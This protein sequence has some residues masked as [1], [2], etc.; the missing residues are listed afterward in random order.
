MGPRLRGDDVSEG[1][2]QSMPL[3]LSSSNRA[4]YLAG[5]GAW[6]LRSAAG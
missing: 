5:F 2:A 1:A 4:A 3:K 6:R